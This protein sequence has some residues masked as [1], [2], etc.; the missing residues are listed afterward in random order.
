M[1]QYC[2]VKVQAV[3]TEYAI[4]SLDHFP[5]VKEA[6]TAKTLGDLLF[7]IMEKFK[8]TDRVL[9]IVTDTTAVMPKAVN[10]V[11]GKQWMPCFSHVLNLMLHDVLKAV[12]PQIESLFTAVHMM[13][14]STKWP[15][16]IKHA[17]ISRIATFCPTRWYS[18]S[19][20]L[21][22]ASALKK[23]INIFLGEN[24]TNEQPRSISPSVWGIVDKFRSVVD[25]FRN[26]SELLENDDFGSISH[27][28]EAR[29]ILD[30]AFG[31]PG[32]ADDPLFAG[33]WVAALVTHWDLHVKGRIKELLLRAVYLNPFVM[34]T[35]CLSVQ[36][37]ADGE[38]L[39]RHDFSKVVG[40]ADAPDADEQEDVPRPKYPSA[41]RADLVQPGAGANELANF[42]AVTRSA[43]PAIDVWKWWQQHKSVFPNVWK[44][45]A[46]VLVVPA[47]S[48]GP[49][50]QFS[51]AQRIKTPKRAS[52]APGRLQSMVFLGENLQITE[53]VLSDM[54]AETPL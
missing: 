1:V 49:E 5:L 43:M 38:Q 24:A 40:T 10:E 13:S 4:F 42:L 51:R 9:R 31:R 8:I 18:M 20:M 37:R 11:L 46:G 33:A 27:V 16:L 12:R 44:L 22:N 6:A 52:M 39:L 26:A 23:E 32:I 34:P 7:Q 48:A 29:A 54:K 2:G 19:R 45:A 47:T 41:T 35:V 15:K 17:K 50:R 21:K 53:A 14:G 25:T 36:E 28:F 3:G 30:I